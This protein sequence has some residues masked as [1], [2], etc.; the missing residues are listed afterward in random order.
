MRRNHV[1]R[2]Y[3]ALVGEPLK[4][5]RDGQLLEAALLHG[6]KIWR[7]HIGLRPRRIIKPIPA[8]GI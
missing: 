5:D 8:G 6:E 4:Y 1:A 7:R 2:Q 3:R